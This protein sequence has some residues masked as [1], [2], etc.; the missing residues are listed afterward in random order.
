M[1]KR[2]RLLVGSKNLLNRMIEFVAIHHDDIATPH[3]T[4]FDVRASADYLESFR[5]R[6]A[7]VGLFH[8]YLVK[9]SVFYNFHGSSSI[10]TAL[11]VLGSP[12]ILKMVPER[13]ITKLAPAATSKSR[14]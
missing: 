1:R 14:I 13:G 2:K 4:N 12:G 5:M 11:G 7:R 8:L 9:K 10:R 3:A 6:R